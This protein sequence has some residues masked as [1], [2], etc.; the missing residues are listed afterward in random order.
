[1][2]F[3]VLLQQNPHRMTEIVIRAREEIGNGDPREFTA[4][5]FKLAGKVDAQ[6]SHCGPHVLLGQSAP[7]FLRFS[8]TSN[9]PISPLFCRVAPYR[10]ADTSTELGLVNSFISLFSMCSDALILTGTPPASQ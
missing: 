9:N 3:A 1:M 6:V 2:M 7:Y 10:P 5:D 8:Q 4:I